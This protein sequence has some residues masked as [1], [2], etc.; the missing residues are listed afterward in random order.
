[1]KGDQMK[2]IKKIGKLVLVVGSILAFTKLICRVCRLIT[3]M[4]KYNEKAVFGGKKINYIYCDYHYKQPDQQKYP[5]KGSRHRVSPLP[6]T[7]K[8]PAA[9]RGLQQPIPE[10]TQTR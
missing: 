6:R 8:R 2:I 1:M 7:G 10:H 4:D 5:R 9:K 3:R